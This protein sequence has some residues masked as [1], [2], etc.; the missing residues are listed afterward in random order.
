MDMD[1]VQLRLR[2]EYVLDVS[3]FIA[4]SDVDFTSTSLLFLIGHMY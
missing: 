4:M 1:D 3:V 2:C